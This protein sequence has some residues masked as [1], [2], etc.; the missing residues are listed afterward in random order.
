MQLD[1][2][3]T[4]R[5]VEGNMPSLK[6]S[7]LRIS[8]EARDHLMETLSNLYSDPAMAVIRE[9]Y[10]N[11]YDS[12]KQAGVTR[13][14]EITLPTPYSP[15]FIVR[16][17]GLGMSAQFI[18]DVFLE[19]GHS[20]KNKNNEVIG[21]L[22]YG[23]KSG[24]AVS[25]QFTVTSYHDGKKITVLFEKTPEG[26]ESNIVSIVDTEEGNG[27]IVT[28]PTQIVGKISVIPRKV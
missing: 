16:D 13:P 19:Y 17:Y 6:K 10:C 2:I 1:R 26:Y 7:P 22:G 5:T 14:V 8:P 24:F 4:G 18:D 21:A 11:G 12:H 9:Y 28:I 15:S 23:G 27:V 3:N 20:T 25:D